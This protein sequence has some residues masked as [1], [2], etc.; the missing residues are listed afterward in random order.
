MSLET[1]TFKNEKA[2][3]LIPSWNDLDSLTFD[4]AKR[5]LEADE[6]FD[7]VVALAKGAWPMSRSFVD[8]LGIDQLASLGVRFYSGINQRMAEPEVYQELPVDVKGKK[9][10]LFDDVAD[11]GESLVFVKKYLLKLGA[12]S[13]KTATI[14]LKDRSI[15]KPDYS[16]AKTN[17]WIIFPFELREMMSLLGESWLKTGI[18]K[19]EIVE[20]FTQLKFPKEISNYFY[21]VK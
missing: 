11:T 21:P 12:K 7:V 10:L 4:L 15:V 9:I 19:N 3:Y 8:Y 1:V 13:V 18:G 17:A 20:R 14:F 6:G 5:I 2:E 16:A